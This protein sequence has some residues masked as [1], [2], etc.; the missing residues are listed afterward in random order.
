MMDERNLNTHSEE[1]PLIEK[2][3]PS[4]FGQFYMSQGF[5]EKGIVSNDCGPTSLAMIINVILKQEN[6][7]N[8]SLRKENIIYQTHFSIWDR[9]PKTIPSVGGATAP[10]GLV[11]AFNQWMQ[12]LGLPWSA[13][14]YNCANRALILE[15]I[16][17]GK[18]ISAL[19]I[20]KNGGAHWVNI[21]DFSAEDDMLYVLDPN[22]YLVHLPQSR[23]VQKESW[24]K[25]S[26][27]WQRKSVWS[28]LLGLDRE[29]VIYSRNL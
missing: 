4:S 18:F 21:I 19:K 25:F 13:E 11:S 6:I 14:R 24:E 15:K 27:D 8:L 9:L 3:F 2:S 12:K 20:W 17:S 7:H 5:R 29:L 22:P 23:R 1:E 28:T 26:N 10:W 16:I